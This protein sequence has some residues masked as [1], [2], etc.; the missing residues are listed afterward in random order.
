MQD[1]T[2]GEHT[3]YQ[4]RGEAS[5]PSDTAQRIHTELGNQAEDSTNQWGLL[6]KRGCPQLYA[7]QME[8][9]NEEH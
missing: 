1:I 6:L 8:T 2:E 7:S 5:L 3:G 9:I 4:I